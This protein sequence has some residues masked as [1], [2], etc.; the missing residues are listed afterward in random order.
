MA[1]QVGAEAAEGVRVDP[2]AALRGNAG[3]WSEADQFVSEL[4]EAQRSKRAFK[5]RP[6]ES[7]HNPPSAALVSRPSVVSWFASRNPKVPL[8]TSVLSSA[9]KTARART[10]THTRT[11]ARTHARAREHPPSHTHTHTPQKLFVILR[12]WFTL[13]VLPPKRQYY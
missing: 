9:G 10:H 1:S 12:R 6:P 8:P 11:H 5:P 3:E 2:R 7:H 4:A 13:R